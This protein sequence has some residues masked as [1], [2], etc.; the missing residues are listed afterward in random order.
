MLT[1]NLSQGS[2]GVL[3]VYYPFTSV[4]VVAEPPSNQKLNRW[5]ADLSLD[6]PWG[7]RKNAAQKLGSLRSERAIPGLLDALMVD[8]FWM[9]RCA[10]IQALVM[11]GDPGAIPRLRRVARED[12]F[13]AV[14]SYAAKAIERLS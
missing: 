13:Q 9:V 10:I 3:D 6:N 1:E 8:P 2:H 11:I 14:R 12:G 7:N 4:P 5:L